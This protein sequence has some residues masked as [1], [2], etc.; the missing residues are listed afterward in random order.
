MT[1]MMERLGTTAPD[2]FTSSLTYNRGAHGWQA[3]PAGNDNRAPSC[4][5]STIPRAPPPRIRRAVP[6]NFT[7]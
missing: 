5:P 6:F 7:S 2:S 4:A 1:R 3:I